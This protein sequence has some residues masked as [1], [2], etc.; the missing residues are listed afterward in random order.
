MEI[1]LIYIL[2]SAGLISL[3]YILYILLLKND[4]SFTA[5]RKFLLGGIFTSLILPA[6]YFT[7]KVLINDPEIVYT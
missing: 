7:K 1:L 3:F 4:T 5:N 6:I 2:K